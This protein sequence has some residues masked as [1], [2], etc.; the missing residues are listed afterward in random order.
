[1]CAYLCIY[2]YLNGRMNQRLHKAFHGIWF[3][4]VLNASGICYCVVCIVP[5]SFSMFLTRACDL[6]KNKT[7]L[8]FYIH[9]I[10]KKE[11]FP[12]GLPFVFAVSTAR[13]LGAVLEALSQNKI[14]PIFQI[15]KIHVYVN[16]YIYIYMW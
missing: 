13:Q 5:Q 15:L 4:Y 16:M 8:I 1:M 3:L 12:P 2:L 6:Q 11:L 9:N 10:L 14:I 7:L